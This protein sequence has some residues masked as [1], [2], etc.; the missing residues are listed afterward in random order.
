MKLYFV[1]KYN[2]Q[3]VA[4]LSIAFIVLNFLS[5][6][7]AA[8]EDIESADLSVLNEH[9][10][11]IDP[12]HGGIDS[13]ASRNQIIEKEITLAIS[14]KLAR[15]LEKNGAI[16]T[17]TRKEDI[18]FY[19]KG[20]GGKRNDLLH[21]IKM[22]EDSD[23]EIFISI[24]CNTF[25]DTSLSGAQVFYNP[26]LAQNK[27]LGERL[28]KALREFPP[29]NKRQAKEDSRILLLNG[30]TI[31]GVLIET[32]YISNPKEALLLI[33]DQYQEKLVE[34]ISKALAYHFSQSVTR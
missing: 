17:V 28:Q 15:C 32:G 10:I 30:T 3:R 20:K 11:I 9:R 4:I 18:D 6:Y 5:V 14:T 29:N 16:V 1:R 31:P 7:Y 19:T 27:V 22:I 13:G 24:H 25:P 12:G 26:K 2:F 33:D 34:Q 21:R 23:A 8:E